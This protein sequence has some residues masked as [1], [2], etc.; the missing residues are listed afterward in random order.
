MD[1]EKGA[2]D[3]PS[4]KTVFTYLIRRLKEI[5]PSF[6]IMQPTFGYPQVPAVDAAVNAAWNVDGSSNGLIVRFQ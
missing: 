5:D 1:I 2:G 6:I 3:D 4:A